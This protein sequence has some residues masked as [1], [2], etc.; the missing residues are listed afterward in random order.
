MKIN[1]GILIF[2]TIMGAMLPLS[3]YAYEDRFMTVEELREEKGAIAIEAYNIGQGFVMEPSLFDKEG[4]STGEITVEVLERK[5]IGY[6]GNN[7]YFSGFEFDDRRKAVYPDYLSGYKGIF[8]ET[9]SGDGYLAEFDY[10][11]M[12]GWCYTIN[13]WWASLGVDSSYPC[14]TVND[15]NTN[16]DIVLG[17]V[18]RWHYTVYGYGVDCG[19]PGNAMAEWMGGNL[20]TQADKSD[21]IFTLAAIN[22][23]YGNSDSDDVYETALA[24]AADPL[25]SAEEIAVQE[26]I[27]RNYITDN[28]AEPET[29]I[30][31]CDSEYV[32]FT[33]PEEGAVVTVIFADYENDCLN[34]VK[35]LPVVTEKMNGENVMSVPV[36][37]GINIS[38]ND[39]IMLWADANT[40]VPLCSAY[41]VG[42]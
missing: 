30:I 33:F 15:Y 19:F 34:D 41:V 9:G 17:D 35:M 12:G 14:G 29:E 27:L 37:E 26:S 38:A 4:K 18:I 25:A 1:S 42:G 21:L 10:S 24:V 7:S 6:I 23:Y 31:G 13:D 22:D 39:K 16:K 2:V 28:F 36:H 32:Y 8:E 20:F 5:G 11:Y 3:S 40:C